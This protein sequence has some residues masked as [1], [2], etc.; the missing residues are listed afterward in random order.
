M[1]QFQRRSSC[2]STSIS[3]IKKQMGSFAWINY[4]FV[5]CNDG[6]GKMRSIT[7]SQRSRSHLHQWLRSPEYYCW[8]RNHRL[9]DLFNMINSLHSTQMKCTVFRLGDLRTS[10][11]P[12]CCGHSG[13]WR[14]PYCWRCHGDKGYEP[15]NKDHRMWN[16]RNAMI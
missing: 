5:G 12:R 9:V 7:I 8:T 1:P 15:V 6:R 3:G 4:S 16:R 2:S 13:W 10:S 14:W 11:V